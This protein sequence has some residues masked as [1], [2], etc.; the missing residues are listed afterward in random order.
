[1]LQQLAGVCLT[2]GWHLLFKKACFC[3]KFM[4]ASDALLLFYK[5]LRD[6]IR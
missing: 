1:M 3:E 5:I 2:G 6:G 4:N